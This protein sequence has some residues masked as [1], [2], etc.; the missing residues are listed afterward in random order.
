ME[1]ADFWLNCISI[2]MIM[3]DRFKYILLICMYF[4]LFPSGSSAQRLRRHHET[5][6]V[7]APLAEKAGP[8]KFSIGHPKWFYPV[9][10]TIEI[11]FIGDVM[12]HKRQLEYNHDTFL[13][14][15]RGR[16]KE[17][18][19]AVANMEFTLAGAPYS[20]YPAFSAPDSYAQYVADC[21][22]DVF[23]TA[24]NHILDKGVRGL[25]R[26]LEVYG[27]MSDRVFMTGTSV[28]EKAD[29]ITYPLII[30]A[31]GVRVALV[32]FTY[33]TNV[34]SPQAWPKVNRMVRKDIEKAFC[35]AI[36]RGADYIV[37]LPH[38]G[39]EYELEHSVEQEELA[40]WMAELGADAIIGSHPHVV[41]DSTVIK[42]SDGRQVP[43]FYSLGNAVSNMSAPNTRLELAVTVRIERD[44]SGDT[45]L[46]EPEA[47]F[48]W[49]TLPGKIIDNYMT[50]PVEEYIGKREL[51]AQPADYDNML[52]T[53]KRVRSATG[54]G[55]DE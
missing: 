55:S 11:V 8:Q 26:T 48:L 1:V 22:V 53:L 37:A 43:V 16:L 54:I 35:R 3:P 24:N 32:N 47:E 51:W 12:M 23:L 33:G 29:S 27:S 34:G 7:F 44:I 31:R 39:I 52:V 14:G 10:D 38:W 28:N 18:D 17:A 5:H 21:G 49:C 36:E 13:E 41:Q 45:R 25:E 46:L 6:P 15:I 42:T 20:G 4:M 40:V 50:I 30:P 19:L 2:H 9:R